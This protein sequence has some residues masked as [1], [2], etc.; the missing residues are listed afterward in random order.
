[1]SH[2]D[3]TSTHA[4]PPAPH[5][6]VPTSESSWIVVTAD[7]QRLIGFV[8]ADDDSSYSAHDDDELRIGT[9]ATF[10]DALRALHRVVP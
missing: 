8:S 4:Q 7:H 10:D 2:S 5:V 9:Y 1:M 3:R 6:A